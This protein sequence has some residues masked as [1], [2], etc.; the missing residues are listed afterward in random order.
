M[1][2]HALRDAS[3]GIQP[4]W[5]T[6]LPSAPATGARSSRRRRLRNVAW[7]L[8]PPLTFV[9]MVGVWAAAVSAFRI[10]AYLLP[11]PGSI[12]CASSPMHPC[13]GRIRSPR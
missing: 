8:L 11:G 5:Q 7:S 2:N 4:D 10:P 12:F 6:T 1:A 3:P 13:C 9:A